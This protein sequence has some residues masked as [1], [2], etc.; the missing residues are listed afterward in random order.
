M[1][2]TIQIT[3][4][5]VYMLNNPN[6]NAA[7]G[8]FNTWISQVAKRQGVSKGKVDYSRVS[9]SEMLELSEAQFNAANVP[10]N[11]RALYYTKWNEFKATLKSK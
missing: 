2:I 7:K 9:E 5:T 10:K 6:H 1:R 3:A 8:V 11:V 4:P